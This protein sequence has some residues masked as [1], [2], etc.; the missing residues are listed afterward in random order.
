MLNNTTRILTV[1]LSLVVLHPFALRGQGQTQKKDE[2]P[3]ILV[4][5]I[6]VNSRFVSGQNVGIK[7]LITVRND[8]DFDLDGLKNFGDKFR[9]E[10]FSSAKPAPLPGRKEYNHLTVHTTISSSADLEYGTHIIN[11]LCINHAYNKLIWVKDKNEDKEI[12]VTT[13]VDKKHQ[14]KP[15]TVEKAALALSVHISRDVVEIGRVIEYN[16]TI[17]LD[18]KTEILN[19]LSP[20]KLQDLKIKNATNLER[21]VLTPFSVFG[22]LKQERDRGFYR[23]VKYWYT[24]QLNEVNLTKL[25]TIPKLNIF[26][27]N[28]KYPKPV[29]LSTPEFKVRTSSVLMPSSDFHGIKENIVPDETRY[30]LWGKWPLRIAQILAVLAGLC[31]LGSLAILITRLRR[32]IRKSGLIGYLCEINSNWQKQRDKSLFIARFKL[33]R[34]LARFSSNHS[35]NNLKKLIVAIRVCMGNVLG[36]E[37]RIALALTAEELAKRLE[38]QRNG[39]RINI[40]FLELAEYLLDEDIEPPEALAISSSVLR[41]AESMKL[42]RLTYEKFLRLV[43]RTKIIKSL[44]KK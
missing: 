24:I 6:V 14:L 17:F 11:T 21:P 29:Q 3:S 19:Y 15:I 26:Y 4:E 13:R 35:Q 5:T 20:P 41:F 1:W 23:E 12:L 16:L 25:F 8:V 28:P 22:S 44:I 9:V 27:R 33:R 42:T 43:Q 18:K 38:K 31:L 32:K 7:H 34:A 36:V 10:E 2:L 37:Q 39:D 30:N 40:A